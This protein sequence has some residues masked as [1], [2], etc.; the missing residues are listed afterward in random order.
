MQSFHRNDKQRM[1]IA[2]LGMAVGI[3]M[4]AAPA[5]GQEGGGDKAKA[6]FFNLR[7]DEDFSYLDGDPDSYVPDR[8]DFLKNI[9]LFDDWRLDV[10]GEFRV[11]VESRANA[12]FGARPHTA[13]TQQFYRWFVHFDVSYR[14]VFRVFVQ[15]AVVHAEDQDGPFNALHENHGEL[16]QLFFDVRPFGE[17]S[18]FVIRVGRQDLLYGK[19]RLISPLDWASNRRR[20]DAVKIFCHTDLWNFDMFYAKPVVVQ[21]EQ[22]DRYNEEFDFWGMYATYKGIENHGLDLYFMAIDRTQDTVNPNGRVGDQSIYTLGSRFWGKTAGFDYEAELSGQWGK[23]AGDTVQA[24]SWTLVGGYTFSDLNCQPRIGVG[25]D[26]A[27]GDEDPFDGKVGTFNQMFPLGH[28]YFGFLDLIGRQ[29]VTAVNVNMSAWAVPKKVKAKLTFHSFWLNA[30]KDS[31]YNA[32]GAATL[33]DPLGTSGEQ[34]G[35]E[36][37]LTVNWK[38]NNHSSMLVG[39]SHFWDSSFIHNNVFSDD[40]PDFYYLQ[41]QYKF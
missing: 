16:Q 32:G 35:H 25:F 11:R 4:V 15:G 39:Y 30:D 41:Y 31:L 14:D 7:Y 2:A 24:W 21:R 13:N 17:G 37:D 10:G 18:P 1:L 3:G 22:R 9:S 38:I 6:K 34:L 27:S 19:Q 20:F 5:I 28:A 33:R 29:N 8:G 23:W 36:L 26:W 12:A 40:D